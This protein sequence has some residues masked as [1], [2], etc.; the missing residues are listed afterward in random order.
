MQPS[1]LPMGL[2]KRVIMPE[3]NKYR[4]FAS[5][6]KRSG[7]STSNPKD[8]SY[9]PRQHTWWVK[10]QLRDPFVKQAHAEGMVS[11]AAYKLLE[12]HEKYKVF[13][14]SDVVVDLGLGTRRLVSGCIFY[15]P[16]PSRE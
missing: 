13:K 6:P 14:P 11:R 5:G 2:I 7:N 10:R 15:Y 3:T 1:I 12:I 16:A 9:T 8:N 4:N